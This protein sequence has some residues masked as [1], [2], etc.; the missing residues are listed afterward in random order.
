MDDAQ[1]RTVWQQRQFNPRASHISQP[2][3]SLM[4]YTLAK[5]VRQLSKLSEVWD[6]VVPQ[7]IAEHTA[8]ESFNRGVLSVLVDSASHR[9][10]LQTLL[11]GG[12]TGEIRF[13][14]SGAL[15][16]IKLKLGQFYAIDLTGSPRYEF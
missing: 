13:R 12:L 10:Q 1:L 7:E 16:K 15:N 2:L 4:K 9:F 5:R 6:D 11:D 8:L 3:A 14:F